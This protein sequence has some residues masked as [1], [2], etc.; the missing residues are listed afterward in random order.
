MDAYVDIFRVTAFRRFWIGFSISAFGDA[1]SR[2]ALTWFVYD[3]TKSARAVGWLLFWYTGPVIVGGLVAGWLLDRFDRRRVMQADAVFRGLIM[4]G[5]PILYEAGHLTVHWIYAAAAAYGFLMMI[6]LAGGPSIVPSLVQEHQLGTANALEALGFTIGGVLGPVAAGLLIGATG[7]PNVIWFAVLSYFAFALALQ[8]VAIPKPESHEH[9]PTRGAS[10]DE[11]VRLM[12]NRSFLRATT[13]MFF[14]FNV[15]SGMISVWLPVFVDKRLERGAGLYGVLLGTI[16]VGEIASALLAGAVNPRMA[17]GRRISIAQ[18]LSGASVLL[19]LAGDLPVF[20]LVAMFLFGFCSSPLTIWAQTIRMR[21]IP[22]RSRGRAFA[23]LR[24]MMQ[25]GNPVGGAAGGFLTAAIGLTAV[26]CLSSAI[27]GGP[28]VVGLS[29]PA[30]RS[31]ALAL[32]V[33]T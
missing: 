11:V 31:D 8:G 21:I 12:W 9:G 5:I 4:A 6:S 29:I 3:M 32:E 10:L 14:A 18:I 1:V 19:V 2:V 23:L 26:I 15:G 16:A 27:A 28:G 13:L 20:V 17:F 25:S 22:A 7:A 33:G 24:M 30:M